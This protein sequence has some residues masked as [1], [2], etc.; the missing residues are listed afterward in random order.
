MIQSSFDGSL[1]RQTTVVGKER[2][3]DHIETKKNV[4]SEFF[5]NSRKKA[6]PVGAVQRNECNG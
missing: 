6:A 3:A 2:I 4:N 1:R 5:E